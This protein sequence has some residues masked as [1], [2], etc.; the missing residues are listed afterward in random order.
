MT[1]SKTSCAALVISIVALVFAVWPLAFP[2]KGESIAPYLSYSNLET[3][4]LSLE[5]MVLELQCATIN[6]HRPLDPSGNWYWP[7]DK[8]KMEC[9]DLVITK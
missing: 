1:I 9:A 8:S 7:E 5:E 4:E 6:H 3:K 2:A